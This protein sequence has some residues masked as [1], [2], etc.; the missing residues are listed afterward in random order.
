MKSFLTLLCV[1]SALSLPAHAAGEKPALKKW[2]DAEEALMKP[3]SMADKEKLSI[4][5]N[6]YSII[7]VIGIVQKDIGSAV[8]ACGEKNPSLKGKMETRFGAWKGNVEPILKEAAKLL[9]KDI[10]AQKGATP[11][12]I[13][14]VM[15][16][17]DEAYEETNRD[18][19]KQPVT[20]VSACN[21]LV[22]S[23][24]R[25]E[26]EMI[27]LLEQTLLPESVIVQRSRKMDAEEK[28]AAKKAA[29]KKSSD[30]KEP[31]KKAE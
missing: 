29:E 18:I 14:A 22:D 28:A 7:R 31:A 10:D 27:S 6:K 4:L 8:T 12:D 3:L 11:S 25:T 30:K 16:L 9:E 20:T 13:R 24:D 1:F 23:M 5:Q 19:I 21:G 26:N 15:K 17:N 2:R